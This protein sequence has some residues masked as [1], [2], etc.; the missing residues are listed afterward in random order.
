[1]VW[2][3]PSDG[4]VYRLPPV[5]DRFAV[6]DVRARFVI[7]C[8]EGGCSGGECV[9]E[10]SPFKGALKGQRGH[11]PLPPGLRID[12]FYLSKTLK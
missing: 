12:Q 5:R 6:G 1:M 8:G 3:Q 4:D 7:G 10:T 2:R 9:T 11:R